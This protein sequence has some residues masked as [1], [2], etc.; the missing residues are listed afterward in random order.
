MVNCDYCHKTIEG[1][2]D[3]FVVGQYYPRYPFA[4]YHNACYS[5]FLKSGKFWLGP[6]GQVIYSGAT[7]KRGM[8]F[9][10]LF[11]LLVL[12]II[13]L[14]VLPSAPQS[15]LPRAVLYFLIILIV[16][17]PIKSWLAWRR[18]K[19]IEGELL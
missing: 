16:F 3:L 1:K 18:V 13:V 6:R 12:A 15:F 19:R 11:F 2:K 14:G 8:I 10:S 7:A 5:E 17:L 4:I 9:I